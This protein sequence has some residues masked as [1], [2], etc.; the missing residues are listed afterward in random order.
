MQF[1]QRDFVEKTF[2][3]YSDGKFYRYTAGIDN[4]EVSGA[5][6]EGAPLRSLDNSIGTVRGFTIYNVAILERDPEN[7]QVLLRSLT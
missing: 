5:H 7:N 3:F 4:S 1:S 6:V 2:M